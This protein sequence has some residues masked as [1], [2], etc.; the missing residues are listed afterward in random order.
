MNSKTTVYL[1]TFAAFSIWSFLGPILN[2][3]SFSATQN[4]FLI[5]LIGCFNFFLILTFK[6]E[7]W[8]IRKIRL[9][10]NL[11]FLMLISGIFGGLW[12]TSLTLIPIAQ[13]VFLF[14]SLPLFALLIER[15]IFGERLS[16]LALGAIFIGMIGIFTILFGNL[17]K[18]T[19]FFSIGTV[20]VLVAAFLGAIQGFLLKRKL[21]KLYTFEI[22]IPAILLSQALVISPFAFQG[23]WLANPSS[24][25]TTL[26]LG[27]FSSVL[28]Y[29]FYVEALNSLRVSTIRLIGFIE[30][31]LVS[32]WG[33]VFLTQPLYLTTIL[34]GMLILS[35]GYLVV[36]SGE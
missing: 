2:T 35:A 11:L 23:P 24:I 22:I 16:P 10:K 25:L 12:L 19:N 6:K 5:S 26:F 28:A 9:E 36:R 32:I 4:I 34:G 13:A 27:A 7:L 29:Y 3:S 18:G 20:M 15:F 30:P 33:I 17:V 31:F 14:S 1:K 21:N 8:R